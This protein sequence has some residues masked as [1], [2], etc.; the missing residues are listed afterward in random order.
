MRVVRLVVALLV[1]VSSSPN[2]N[3]QEAIS[4][5]RDLQALTVLG[6]ALGA[7]GWRT[8]ALPVA[9]IASGPHTSLSRPA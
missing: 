4:A 6:Q 1:A 2:P 8:G 5:Q 7:A 9:I 3:S